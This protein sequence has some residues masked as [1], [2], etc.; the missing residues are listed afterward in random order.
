MIFSMA[1][2]D[3]QA[4]A[5]WIKDAAVQLV[6]KFMLRVGFGLTRTKNVI[7]ESIRTQI[8]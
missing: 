6:N 5:D 1:S 8:P 3:G 4:K 7:G 2:A